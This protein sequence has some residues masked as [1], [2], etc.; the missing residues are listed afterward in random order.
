MHSKFPRIQSSEETGFLCNCMMQKLYSPTEYREMYTTPFGGTF[1]TAFAFFT[2]DRNGGN[3][4]G[5]IVSTATLID[6]HL[7]ILQIYS[8][9]PW[10]L[11]VIHRA[12]EF[13]ID[14]ELVQRVRNEITSN[15][16]QQT[17]K[18]SMA[19]K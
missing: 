5:N 17:S 3:S 10:W 4:A 19:E 12:I 8:N 16:K 14:E 13:S 18:L 1:I 15:Y 7:S 11:N 9:S 6:E 2:A